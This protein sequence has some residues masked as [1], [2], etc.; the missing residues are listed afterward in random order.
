[1]LGLAGVLLATFTWWLGWDSHAL[2]RGAGSQG[3]PLHTLSPSW[4]LGGQSW[5]RRLCR[6]YCWYPA[7][8]WLLTRLPRWRH[9]VFSGIGGGSPVCDR[10]PQTWQ[11]VSS[12]SVPEEMC[13]MVR[14][15]PCREL[16]AVLHGPCW[17][18]TC[19]CT[20]GCAT[21]ALCHSVCLAHALM[22]I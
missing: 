19:V 18:T 12:S 14:E 3:A 4:R 20:G 21:A 7:S 11:V 17:S 5:F 2:L 1:M 13:T 16:N 8:T 22:H 15:K 10:V 9:L 6:G